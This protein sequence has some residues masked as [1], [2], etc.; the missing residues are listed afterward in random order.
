MGASPYIHFYCTFSCM[1][2]KNVMKM[3]NEHKF[4]FYFTVGFVCGHFRAWPRCS[5]RNTLYGTGV[6]KPISIML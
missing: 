2:V 6:W 5:L 4:M 3:Y 1:L